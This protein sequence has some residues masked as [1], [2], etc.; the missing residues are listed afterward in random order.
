VALLEHVK[1]EMSAPRD[2][3]TGMPQGSVLSPTSYSI[4]INDTPQTFVV[5][6]GFFADDTCA[7]A[8]DRKKGYVLRKLQR[9]LSVVET[10]CERWNT[11]INE[12]KI[13]ANYFSHKLRSLKAH[14]TLNGRNIPFVNHVKYLGVIFDKNDYMETAHR[15]V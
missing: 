3:Q 11:K 15:N 10:R 14:L 7:Y 1:G 8:T 6:Q 4:Y 12:D 5:C 13:Q 2:N 9:G